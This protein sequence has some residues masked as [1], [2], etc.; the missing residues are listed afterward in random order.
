MCIRDSFRPEYGYTFLMR[1]ATPVDR[2]V[3]TIGRVVRSIDPTVPVF[4]AM[5]LT[6]YVAGPLQGQQTSA[7]LLALLAGVAS[8]LAAIGLY[9]VISYAMAQRTK[10][11][12]VRMALGA[13]LGDVLRMVAMQAGALV[14]IGLIVGLAGAVAA[15]RVL[16]SMLYSVGAGD[17]I[18]FA[19]AGAA[20]IIL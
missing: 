20:M 5:P 18:V 6:D 4:N 12:G 1:A 7:R 15:A 2:A 11:I 9:G 17:G 8:A 16:T 3:S 13:Q 10:E 19:G 14:S